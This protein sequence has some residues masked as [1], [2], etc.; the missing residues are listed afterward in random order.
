MSEIRFNHVFV[1]L[2]ALS[3]LTAFV[4]NP[5]YTNRVRNVQA[6]FAPVAAPTRRIAS[7]FH[8]RYGR[9]QDEDDRRAGADVRAENERLRTAML[10]LS[11][12]LEELKRIN[13][14]RNQVGDLRPLCSPVKVIGSD[15]GTRE[16]LVVQR[17]A[18]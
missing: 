12:Q 18:D 8:E 14:D 6:V 5:R 17:A 10:S 13:A 9:A 2:I 1:C 15:T 3:I 4:I 7:V 11:G 16:S